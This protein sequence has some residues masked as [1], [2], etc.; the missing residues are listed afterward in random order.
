MNKRI[1]LPLAAV[2]V[3]GAGLWGVAQ[4]SAASSESDPR[5]SLIQKLADKF[6]VDKSQVQA[7]FDEHRSERQAEMQAKYEDRLKQAVK[8][9]ELTQAQ[10]DKVLAKHNELKT[11]L[12][13]A[14]DKTGTDRRDA[15]ETI[16][17]EAKKWADDNNIAA[18]WLLPM[19]GRGGH[20]H[21]GPGHMMGERSGAES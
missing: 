12:E 9:G 2:A 13:A 6:K 15:M 20:G 18:K 19:G 14:K 5:D 1:A 17:D 16:R 7:V 21:G 11:K 10:A 8:D 3:V 4:A